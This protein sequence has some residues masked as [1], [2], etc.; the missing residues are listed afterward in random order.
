MQR[1]Y[2]FPESFIATDFEPEDWEGLYEYVDASTLPHREEILALIESDRDPDNK[3]WCIKSAYRDDYRQLLAS[4]YPALRHSDYRVEYTVRGFSDTEEIRR[5]MQTQP[6][7]L[8]LQE[9]Y[10]LAQEAEPGSD[11]FVEVFETAVR[12]YPD[13]PAANLNAAN[14][15]MSRN[16]TGSAA[17]YLAKA[18]DTAEADYARGACAAL[19]EDYETAGRLFRQAA[20]RGMP[21]AAVAAE[22]VAL[23]TGKKQNGNNQ[24]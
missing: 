9:F 10:L 23:L 2:D 11:D 24:E 7:K 6:Q 22:Q 12:I 19:N 5:I 3:E 20:E 15:A 13:D 4:C 8:S 1:L 21:Q 18:G 16:D 17:R 14:T